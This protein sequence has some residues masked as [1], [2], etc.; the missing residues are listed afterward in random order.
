MNRL[1]R[2]VYWAALM[3]PA[4]AVGYLVLRYGVNVPFSDQ[5]DFVYHVARGLKGELPLRDLFNQHNE[6]RMVFPM[7]VMLGLAR[8][9]HWNI[10]A[11]M[12]TSLG[13]ASATFILLIRLARPVLDRAGTLAGLWAALTISLLVFSLTQSENWLWGWQ[14]QWF[15]AVLATVGAVA[16]ATGSLERDNPWPLVAAAAGACIVCQLSIASGVAAW[17]AAGLV[18][19]F[20]R[21]RRRILPVWIVAALV[22]LGLYLIGYAKP[23]HHPSPL[24][25]LRT[26]AALL[27]YVGN[28]LSG[29]LARRAAWGLGIAGA[30]IVLAAVAVFRYSHEPRLV[31]PW[32]GL[33]AFAGANA[34][35]TGLGRVGFG[36]EQALE[37]RYVTI[38][39]L[40]SVALVPL[41][42]LALID[43]PQR[44]MRPLVLA[45]GV[46]GAALMTIATVQRDRQG[47]ADFKNLYAYKSLGRECALAASDAA[48]DCLRRLYPNPSVVRDR[49]PILRSFGWSGIPAAEA[50]RLMTI[51]LTGPGGER[52]WSLH[53]DATPAGWLD[54]AE[55]SGGTLT[56]TGWAHHPRGNDGIA[57]RVILVAGTT[58]VGEAIVALDRPDVAAAYRDAG[59]LRT[60]WSLRKEG[61]AVPDGALL[62]AY[63]VLG[64]DIVTPLVGSIPLGRP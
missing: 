21:Q 19:A 4:A 5:W 44:R 11:E 59:Y 16:L 41:W 61:V 33:G 49:M 56:A 17:G 28:Y 43:W 15:L 12:L 45:V 51:T 64:D 62:R 57:R 58:V 14:I 54:T 23:P 36:P 37:S 26:P 52:R 31:A 48:D 32:I 27:T 1:F 13:L 6:H 2:I 39:L 9:T 24:D 29:P 35:V 3:A 46:V 25:A 42:I 60:G 47:L 40:M 34:L 10:V 18:F 22:V 38:A 7:L 55:L 30:F 53:A 8:L 50:G 63:L 20:H